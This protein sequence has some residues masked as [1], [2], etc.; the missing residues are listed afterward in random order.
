MFV[1]ASDS[2]RELGSIS[3]HRPGGKE[4]AAAAPFNAW[5]ARTSRRGMARACLPYFC[6]RWHCVFFQGCQMGG[7][8]LRK[9]AQRSLFP[10]DVFSPPRL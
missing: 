3:L 10:K 7:S 9:K 6:M 4:E 1:A 5:P 8:R 2:A